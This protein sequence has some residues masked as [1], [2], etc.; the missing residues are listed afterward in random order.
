MHFMTT[1]WFHMY[2]FL[3][4]LM[5]VLNYAFLIMIIPF[6]SQQALIIHGSIDQSN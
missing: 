4:V 1:R 3:D 6:L 2:R 5:H